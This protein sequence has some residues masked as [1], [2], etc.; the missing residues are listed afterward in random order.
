M[1]WLRT[2]I[3][4]LL[5]VQSEHCVQWVQ[6]FFGTR[7]SQLYHILQVFVA[8]TDCGMWIK[9]RDLTWGGIGVKVVGEGMTIV[10]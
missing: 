9:A 7:K 3:K 4:L 10:C 5:E 2:G 6:P 1:E 8:A